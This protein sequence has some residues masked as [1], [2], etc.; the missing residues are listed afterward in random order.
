ML[1]KARRNNIRLR[2]HFKTHQSAEVG[3]WLREEGVQ[4]I[5][6][7]SLFM[8]EYFA[9]AGWTDITV[10]FPVNLLEIDRINQ[11]TTK[12]TLN[13]LV[14]S[15]EMRKRDWAKAWNTRCRYL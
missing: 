8:A 15:V 11:L 9:A 10:A 7:S 2:P 6:V 14:E 13:L 4:Y 3:E 1:T 12:C 5:T